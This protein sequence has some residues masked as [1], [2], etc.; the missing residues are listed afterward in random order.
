MNAGYQY[1][2]WIE[3]TI[4]SPH[5]HNIKTCLD[6]LAHEED[7]EI[8]FALEETLLDRLS[9][10][11]DHNNA[12]NFACQHLMDNHAESIYHKALFCGSIDVLEYLDSH[13]QPH[14]PYPKSIMNGFEPIF[15]CRYPM[16]LRYWFNKHDHLMKS[17]LIR[18]QILQMIIKTERVE[19][20]HEYASYCQ[21]HQLLA[22]SFV[23]DEELT[24]SSLIQTC[25]YL[26][27]VEALLS[28]LQ[29][30]T[31][32][33]SYLPLP[34][35]AQ[36]FYLHIIKP[37]DILPPHQKFSIPFPTFHPKIKKE[38]ALFLIDH[39]YCLPNPPQNSDF[40]EI[41]L[42]AFTYQDHHMMTSLLF[43]AQ[44]MLPSCS[45]EQPSPRIFSLR[46]ITIT[47][48]YE[49]E[50][51]LWLFEHY[52]RQASF[53]R[54]DIFWIN[55]TSLHF[56]LKNHVS[57]SSLQKKLPDTLHIHNH[58]IEDLSLYKNHFHLPDE[59]WK[60]ILQK[61]ITTDP[62]SQTTLC[63]LQ[64]QEDLSFYT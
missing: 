56:R 25:S 40:F 46:T 24:F 48:F 19:I 55:D 12:F 2:Q 62:L 4:S 42:E 22:I 41:F 21:R 10:L 16:S 27:F 11:H 64:H 61:T 34:Q 60:N 59:T 28:Y 37:E 39:L 31:Q 58:N 53:L 54:F 14:T 20:L 13:Y 45:E 6:T 38:R 43:L 63:I 50:S 30:E 29:K 5:S 51:L 49:S 9:S 18:H 44:H 8:R 36:R 32:F 1:Q 33:K 47:N 26:P 17:P 57:H 23:L 52:P 7:P 3:N 15:R 35:L